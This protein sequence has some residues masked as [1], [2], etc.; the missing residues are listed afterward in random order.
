MRLQ[1]NVLTFK[2]HSSICFP[3]KNIVILLAEEKRHSCLLHMQEVVQN[4]AV[5][6]DAAK[7]GVKD[8]Q[9]QQ[10]MVDSETT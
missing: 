9:M 5:M 6:N 4:F 7:R 10:N 3:E 2:N 8:I 1:I